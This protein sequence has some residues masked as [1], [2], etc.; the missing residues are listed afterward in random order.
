V[1][2]PTLNLGPDQVRSFPVLNLKYADVIDTVVK[3]NV[4]LCYDE[5]S[6]TETDMNFAGQCIAEHTLA[7]LR[8]LA[9]IQAHVPKM[10]QRIIIPF[11]GVNQLSW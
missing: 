4:K 5:C 1:L 8:K 9:D 10:C 3:A 11:K 6:E 2:A 7:L